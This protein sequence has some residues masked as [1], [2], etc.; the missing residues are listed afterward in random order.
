[1]WTAPSSTTVGAVT[2][3]GGCGRYGAVNNAEITV[4]PVPVQ[5]GFCA[6]YASTCGA[7]NGFTSEAICN[8]TTFPLVRGA[9]G[10]QSG[11]T[12][13]CREYHLG[14]AATFPVGSADRIAHCGHA[15]LTGAGVCSAQPTPAEFCT[16]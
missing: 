12:L 2:I 14:V 9:S 5:Q 1:M 11:N 16:E 4:T 13:A 10:S 8:S 6:L 7:T 3:G 15:G